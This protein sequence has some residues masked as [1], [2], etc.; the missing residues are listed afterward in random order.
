MA[1]LDSSHSIDRSALLVFLV[2]L[3]MQPSMKMLSVARL[4]CLANI[5][6]ASLTVPDLAQIID[7][8]SFNYLSAV[9]PT[10]LTND[11]LVF[12]PPGV[13]EADLA[14]KPFHIYDEEFLSIL[15][16]SPTLTLIAESASNPLYHEAVVW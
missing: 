6:S 13:S 12:Q 15:G 3:L 14:A 16:D 9:T 8:V 1:L 2:P 7:Q 11:S 4:F 5:V 10:N